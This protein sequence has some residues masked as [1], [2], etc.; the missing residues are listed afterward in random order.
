MK[1][2]RPLK[3]IGYAFSRARI[4]KYQK[5]IKV[6]CKAWKGF[7]LSLS[8]ADRAFQEFG[9]VMKTIKDKK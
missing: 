6:F 1:Q 2:V 8:Q 3:Q 7:G 4:K 5:G 9:Q